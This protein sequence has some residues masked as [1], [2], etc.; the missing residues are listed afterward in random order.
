[1]FYN[2]SENEVGKPGAETSGK[3]EGGETYADCH[4]GAFLAPSGSLLKASNPDPETIRATFSDMA[5]VA[6]SPVPRCFAY[7]REVIENVWQNAE[8]VPGTDPALWRRD[9]F[10]ESIYRLDYGRRD[11]RYGWEV[12]DPGIGRRNEGV[13]AMRPVHWASYLRLHESFV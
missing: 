12:Y 8:I 13:Y 6:Q 9:E 2:Q 3:V 4:D 5:T 10:G 1:M 7:E 11:S